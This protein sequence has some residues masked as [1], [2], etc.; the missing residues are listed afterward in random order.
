[1]GERVLGR[2]DTASVSCNNSPACPSNHSCAT[3]PLLLNKGGGVMGH[4]HC[5]VQ[6]VHYKAM[7]RCSS[8]IC[9]AG[10]EGTP[11]R[12]RAYKGAYACETMCFV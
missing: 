7:L 11:G 4:N 10:D 9:M 5:Q 12:F 8:A 2:D 3:D 6:Q 1:M